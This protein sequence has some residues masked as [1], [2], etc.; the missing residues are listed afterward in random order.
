M[1][2]F[3]AV[4]YSMHNFFSPWSRNDCVAK[5]WKLRS[6]RITGGSLS[7]KDRSMLCLRG[8]YI[9]FFLQQWCGEILPF[10]CKSHTELRSWIA[11]KVKRCSLSPLLLRPT[12][13]WLQKQLLKAVSDASKEQLLCSAVSGVFALRCLLRGSTGA[14]QLSPNSSQEPRGLFR[15]FACLWFSN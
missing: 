2:G 15:V 3:D 7:M 11:P 6:F 12:S 5:C 8:F 14:P 13:W 4:L 1:S 9:G 10:I